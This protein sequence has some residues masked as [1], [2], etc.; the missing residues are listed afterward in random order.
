MSIFIVMLKE[1]IDNLRDRQTVFYALLF[2]PILLPLLIGGSLV[3]SLKQL[4]I[5]FED[6]TTLAVVNIED[7]PTLMEFLYTRNVDT[8][9]APVDPRRPAAQR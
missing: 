8:E 7:A 9:A 3:A 4:S 5:D 1:I 2:G 6:V